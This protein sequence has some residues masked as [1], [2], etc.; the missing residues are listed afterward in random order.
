MKTR[1][2]INTPGH[3]HELTFSCYRRLPLLA[4]DRTRN[5]LIDS[6][7]TA[8]ARHDHALWAYVIMPEHAHV[9]VKPRN[10]D[11]QIQALCKTFKQSVSRRALAWLRDHD[12]AFLEKLAGEWTT[13]PSKGAT[14]KQSLSVPHQPNRRRRHHFWQPG[15]GYD[16]NIDDPRTLMRMID[17]LHANPVRRDLVESPTDWPWSSARQYAGMDG[18]LLKMDQPRI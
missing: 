2:A 7:D 13:L 14:D 4:R 5:W 11:Y 9:I 16:R 18:V 15:G 1:K 12:P 17:Y 3:A 8:R 10:P 6:L